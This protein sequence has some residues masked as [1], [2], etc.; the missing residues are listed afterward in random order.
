MENSQKIKLFGSR[1]FSSNFDMTLNFLKQNYVSILKGI[2]ILIPVYLIV[3]YFMPSSTSFS[4]SASVYGGAFNTYMSM[5]TLGFFI[6][7]ILIGLTSLATFL[8]IASYMALYAK[9]PDGVIK[10]S[11]VWSKVSKA[12]LPMLG[13]SIIFGVLVTIGTILCIIPGIIVYV[14][15]GF[16]CYVYVNE[17]RSIIDSFYRS[18]ELITNNWWIT[19]GYGLVFLIIVGIIGAIFA[20]PTYLGAIGTVFGIGFLTGEVYT[21]ISALISYAGSFLL[22]PIIYIAMGVMYY[23]H[24]NKLEG[25]DMESEIDN[26]GSFPDNQKDQ[27]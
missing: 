17:D 1:D 20:I 15:L 27:Y 4:P 10:S 13:G 12:F 22:Y 5:F 16:Y 18:Y 26:I 6:A 24:R 9:S 2:L 14:Y 7:Y 8:Y 25:I 21:Y 19:F 11:D 23:S 3:A